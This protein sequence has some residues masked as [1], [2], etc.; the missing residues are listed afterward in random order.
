MVIPAFISSDHCG[1]GKYEDH[2]GEEFHV[3]RKGLPV[4]E[5]LFK[6]YLSFLLIVLDFYPHIEKEYLT[7]DTH[8]RCG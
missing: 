4:P 6:G 2:L 5:A 7:D 8:D 3:F 1:N